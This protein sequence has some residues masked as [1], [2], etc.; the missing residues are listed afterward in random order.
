MRH[1]I[2]MGEVLDF[3]DYLKKREHV[4][5]CSASEHKKLVLADDGYRVVN[6]DKERVTTDLMEAVDLYNFGWR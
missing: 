3:L 1:T 4:V 5:A 2:T 6:G